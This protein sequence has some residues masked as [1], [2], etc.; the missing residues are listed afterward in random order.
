MPFPASAISTYPPPLPNTQ[1]TAF[2]STVASQ[3]STSIFFQPRSSTPD[4]QPTTPTT[5]ASSASSSHPPRTFDYSSTLDYA[6]K[7]VVEC[8]KMEHRLIAWLF[9]RFRHT[10]D[11]QT[12]Q[13]SDLVYN[14]VKMISTHLFCEE[15]TLY[16]AD[17][18]LVR[19]AGWDNGGLVADQMIKEHFVLKGGL[20]R[21]QELTPNDEGFRQY[22]FW[23]H[24]RYKRHADRE[25]ADVSQNPS[26]L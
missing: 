2:N 19:Q 17:I 24:G 8:L 5:A 3:P 22:V 14:I 9:E 21:L 1:R 16:A 10:D 4:T 18:G 12:Q 6:N 23:L 13:L 7:D 20:Y 11:D 25:E 15:F 26:I